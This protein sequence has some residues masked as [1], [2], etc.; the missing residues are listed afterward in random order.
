MT[1]SRVSFPS[2]LLL[3]Q[4]LIRTRF[5]T[6]PVAIS[7]GSPALA[8]YSLALTSL[9]TRFVYRR[10][11][12]IK[13]ESRGAVARALVSLQQIPLE[14]TRDE[15]LLA[16]IPVKEQWRQEVADRLNRRYVWP[17]AIGSSVTWVVI[18]FIFTLVDSFVDL[19][20]SS[21]GGAEGHAVGTLWLW[22][23]CLVIGWI[24]VPT[25]TRGESSSAACHTRHT[26]A[27][28]A[29]KR[30]NQT[31]AK[32]YN[33]AKTKISERLPEPNPLPD[34]THSQST[35]SLQSSAETQDDHTHNG[36]SENPTANHSAITFSRSTT[37]HST[38]P[39]TSIYPNPERLLID[40]SDELGALNRDEL[41][42]AA[43]F[44]YSRIMR[45]LVLVDDVLRALENLTRE[46]DEVGSVFRET[47]DFGNCVTDS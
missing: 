15:P 28:R 11:Q 30:I 33:S 13:H 18:A 1:L 32:A 7:L 10:A 39:Q 12:R 14:L 20:V 27:N 40:V 36:V 24:W 44:N 31:A 41:P 3:V 37:L 5:R 26:A 22:L 25:F 19:D 16:F 23:A 35:V 21:D 38:T 45:Y 47:S 29:A 9:N 8:A 34:P 4:S 6:R 43:T 17:I 46:D 42:L 2:T